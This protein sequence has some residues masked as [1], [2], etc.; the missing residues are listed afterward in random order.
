MTTWDK[1]KEL[2]R[3]PPVGMTRQVILK[4]VWAEGDLNLKEKRSL[5]IY[6]KMLREENAR[7]EKHNVFLLNEIDNYSESL[8]NKIQKLEAIREQCVAYNLTWRK[9]MRASLISTYILKKHFP[10]TKKEVLGE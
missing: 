7:L 5:L 9:D 2:Y 1:L 10:D 8:I 6:A 3:Q 4:R